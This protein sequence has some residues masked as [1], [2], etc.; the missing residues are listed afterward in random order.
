[1]TPKDVAKEAE[2]AHDLDIAVRVKAEDIARALWERL[3]MLY[4]A[5]YCPLIPNTKVH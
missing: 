2:L 5:V 1:M 4:A 3:Q